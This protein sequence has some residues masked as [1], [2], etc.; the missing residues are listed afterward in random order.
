[1][2]DWS[3]YDTI[4][5]RYDGAW[6]DRFQVAARFL[7]ERLPLPPAAAVLDV[8]TG[9]GI[10]LGAL[11]SAA[12][13]LAGCDRSMGMMRL[14]R[15]RL[16]AAW[17]VSADASAL[18]FVDGSFDAVTA[19]FV[20]SH[21]DDP[22]SGLRE[23]LRVLKPGGRFGMTSW[24]ADTDARSA[25]WRELAAEAVSSDRLRAAIAR[26]L[27]NEQHFESP[28]NVEA[29]LVE[30]GYREVRVEAIALDYAI[31]LDEFLA[32]REISSG[33]R[34]AREAMGDQ[35]WS[36]WTAAARAALERRFGSSFECARQVLV[37]LGTR[38][39]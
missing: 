1:M 19:S 30:A 17:L 39:D 18:P 13:R 26:V 5:A 3:S 28:A 9:T 8:G 25:A 34:F 4:A 6:G 23:A 15:S 22:Q 2:P 7:S 14:A 32:D 10:V 11:A 36:L 24:A 33:G 21:L 35:V 20:V 37:G 31:S 12:A 16:P 27:P 29:A 38:A